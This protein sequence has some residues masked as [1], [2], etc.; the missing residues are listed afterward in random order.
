MKTR[1]KYRTLGLALC[2]SLTLQ[3]AHAVST[4]TQTFSFTEKVTSWENSPNETHYFYFPASYQTNVNPFNTTLGVLESVTL[5]WTFAASFEGFASSDPS[6]GSVSLSVNGNFLIDGNSYGGNGASGGH[7]NNADGPISMTSSPTWTEKEFTA[8]QAGVSYNPANWASLSGSQPWSA[9]F[10]FS[11]GQLS[12]NDV[13]SGTF[14]SDLGLEV[15]YSYTP[16]PVP[17]PAGA[18]GTLGLLAGGTFFR[19][20]KQAA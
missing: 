15:T 16:S 17:E 18:L 20:R 5:R 7:G 1:S 9:E 12:Y 3:S 13:A 10:V 14:T 4:I 19:R 8:A 6:G 11:S 2:A